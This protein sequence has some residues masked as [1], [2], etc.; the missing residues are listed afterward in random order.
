MYTKSQYVDYQL[1]GGELS[2]CNVIDYFV[3]TYEEDL[4]RQPSGQSGPANLDNTSDVH[5]RPGRHMN[6]RVR[7]LPLHPKH[8]SKQ[9]V[10]QTSGHNTL[11]NFIGRYFPRRDDPDIYPFYCASMLMLLKPWRNI[12]RDLKTPSESW[13]A[14]FKVFIAEAPKKV[15]DII[16]GIQYFHECSAAAR[17]SCEDG[18]TQDE[19][20][21]IAVERTEV[22]E[23]N[24]FDLGED[25]VPS[26]EPNR[27]T[28]KG[29]ADLLA[30]QVSW[31]E[32]YHGRHVVEQGK[33]AKLFKNDDSE[34]TMKEVPK[35]VTNAAGGDL[36]MLLNWRK[37]M[38]ADVNAQNL[39]VDVPATSQEAAEFNPA[40]VEQRDYTSSGVPV[41]PSVEHVS[42]NTHA[43]AALSSMNPTELNAEQFRAYS[44]VTWHLQETL[45]GN[46]PPPL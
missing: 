40:T 3:N 19:A 9:R 1:R 44:I 14:A 27:Y 15:L 11:P 25:V 29:L 4:K 26:A 28:E 35:P 17:K 18:T 6:P 46:A 42:S 41:E 24:E 38:D 36:S 43:E 39:R 33:R 30:S 2:S 7:Y 5:R 22:D 13:A 34:W 31:R 21:G 16:S 32:E 23:L 20:H 45:A 10:I 8:D 12:D 37:Q